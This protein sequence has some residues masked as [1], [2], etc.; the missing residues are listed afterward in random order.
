MNNT[1]LPPLPEF[2]TEWTSHEKEVITDMLICYA[3]AAL[4]SQAS[5]GAVPELDD[6][7]RES[8]VLSI[9]EL[10]ELASGVTGALR[11]DNLLKPGGPKKATMADVKRKLPYTVSRL[12]AIVAK[13]DG[14]APSPAAESKQAAVPAIN[15]PEFPKFPAQICDGM[16]LEDLW[17]YACLVGW[18]CAAPSPAQPAPVDEA[19]LEC[20]IPPFGWR[21][22]RGAGHSG[23]C[24]AVECPED[25]AAVEQGFK[26]LA[27]QP[28]ADAAPVEAKPVAYRVTFDDFRHFSGVMTSGRDYVQ[29]KKPE[30]DNRFFEGCDSLVITP[31][32]ASQPFP[33]QGEAKGGM[34]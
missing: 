17:E 31:L 24:A 19:D 22:T 11:S 16:P 28:P 9:S 6:N 12:R 7:D 27:A 8:L 18:R 33:A 14:A 15:P 1:E 26:R 30:L 3:R 32:Y 29:F 21:C 25:V 10:S 20:Q 34:K 13:L 5:K 23:P 2:S 4:A